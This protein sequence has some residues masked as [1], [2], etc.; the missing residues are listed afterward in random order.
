MIT[1]I[2]FALLVSIAMLGSLNAGEAQTPPSKGDLALVAAQ[3]ILTVAAINHETREVTLQDEAGAQK[4]FVIGKEARNLD[5]VN[6]GDTVTIKAAEAVAFRLFPVDTMTKGRIEKTSVSRSDLGQKP[7][8]TIS[9][10]IELTARVAVL[11]KEKR[12][13]TLEGKNADLIMEV[14]PEVDL[15]AVK[16]GDTVKA[17]FLEMISITVNAPAK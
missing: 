1:R 12:M 7:H 6:P 2:T 16:V 9:R 13:V 3:T 4:T 10:E 11:D 8:V 15:E 5:Q 14:T 17:N